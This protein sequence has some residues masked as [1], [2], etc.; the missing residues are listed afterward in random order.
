MYIYIYI[1]TIHVH[2]C[3]AVELYSYLSV[4]ARFV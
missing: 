1:D 4:V 2:T 3:L